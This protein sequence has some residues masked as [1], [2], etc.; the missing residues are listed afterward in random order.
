MSVLQ[1]ITPYYKVLLSTLTSYSVLQTTTQFSTHVAQYCKMLPALQSTTPD[2]KVLLPQDVTP[3]YSVL[4]TI[5]KYVAV[6]QNTTPYHKVLYYKVLLRTTKHYS[7]RQSIMTLLQHTQRY[8][9]RYETS[10]PV[11][12]AIL[13]MQNKLKLW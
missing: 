9:E 8:E 6:L 11:H 12:R 5:T 1:N 13:K 10:T 4:Q 3:H 2:Y 7:V